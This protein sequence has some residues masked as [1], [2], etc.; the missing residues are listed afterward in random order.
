MKRHKSRNDTALSVDKALEEYYFNPEK[1]GAYY[2]PAKLRNV[3]LDKGESKASLR[4]V[5]RFVN[6]QDAYSLHRPPVYRFK[7]MNVRVNFLNEMFDMDLADMSRYTKFNENVRYL[8]V[9][10][11]ILS[12]YAFVLPLVNKRP[13][14]VLKAFKQII[15]ERKPRKVRTDAGS[16]FKGIFREFLEKENITHTIARNENIKSNY[17]ERFN[18]TLKSLITRY[19]THNNTKRYVDILPKLVYNYN[20]TLHSSLPEL[21]PAQVTKENQVKVWDHV[22]LKPLRKRIKSTSSMSNAKRY[23]FKVGDMVRISYLRRPFSTV[24]DL[25]WTEEL[26]KVARRYK[27]QGFAQYKLKD[28]HDEPLTGSF[29]AN[30]L[31]KV[32]KAEDVLW[33]VEKILKRKKVKGKTYALVRWLGWPKK[34]DSY[35]EESELKEV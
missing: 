5:K 3:L 28:F 27:K 9:T 25:K 31:K 18:R 16:E 14:T 6:N 17:V 11:D 7:R 32:N 10:V 22:Y 24:L 8:L 21:S 20:H 26:F 2:G 23:L 19:M 12:R 33:Q 13:E 1:P 34:Y 15:E 4:R 29:Y 30:E 35:V